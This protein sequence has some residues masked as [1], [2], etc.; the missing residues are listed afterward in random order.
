MNS[1]LQLVPMVPRDVKRILRNLHSLRVAVTMLLYTRA[2]NKPCNG[3]TT[4][5]MDIDECS[6]YIH[7]LS[8]HV[9]KHAYVHNPTHT[10]THSGR[11]RGGQGGQS[12]PKT[13]SK[14]II[15]VSTCA[16]N[17]TVDHCQAFV[18]S[19]SNVV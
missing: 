1:P 14:I 8:S 15:I 13:A 3:F 6:Q 10:H 9:W 11:S 17:D 16:C 12:L 2:L 4:A 5:C 7:T 18:H 19:K